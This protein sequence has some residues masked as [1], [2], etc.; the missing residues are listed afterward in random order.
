[1]DGLDHQSSSSS[2][3]PPP[4]PPPLPHPPLS[5]A[6]VSDTNAGALLIS[7]QHPPADARDISQDNPIPNSDPHMSSDPE[8]QSTRPASPPVAA[9]APPPH[10]KTEPETTETSAGLVAP[11]GEPNSLPLSDVPVPESKLETGSDPSAAALVPQSPQVS[12][13]FLLAS[14]RRRTMS[15]E[16][17][18]TVARVKEFVWNAWPSGTTVEYPLRI[19]CLTTGSLY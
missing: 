3:P 15:F 10:S 9:V 11:E 6:S 7:S 1:M 19:L 18:T 2:T 13:T 16:P 17:Q 12:L 5:T 4:L 8:F 14:G